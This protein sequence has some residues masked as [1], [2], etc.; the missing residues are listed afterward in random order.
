M[1]LLPPLSTSFT[2][3]DRRKSPTTRSLTRNSLCFRPARAADDLAVLDAPQRRVA[4]P[5][6]QVPAVEERLSA[7]SA[8]ASIG[9]CAGLAR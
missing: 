5:A 4:L 1:P 9:T 7:L 8:V 3:S 6:G 2:C